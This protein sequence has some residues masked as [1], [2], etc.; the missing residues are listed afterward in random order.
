M[1]T[2]W[3]LRTLRRS[4]IFSSLGSML[5]VLVAASTTFLWIGA[6]QPSTSGAATEVWGAYSGGRWM[7]AD[8]NGGYWIAS[9][10]G[11]VTPYGGAPSLGSPS[12]FGIHLSQP[13]MGMAAT[14][15]GHGYWLVASDGGIFSFG[16]AAFHGSTGS[17]HLN[18]P[19]VGMAATPTGHGYWLV[20]SDGGIFSFGDAAFYGSTGSIHL[21][22]PIV[23][24]AATPTGHGYSLVASD[25]GIF[26]F[27]DATFHGSTGS[28]HLNQPIVGM[29]S[30]PDG[31]GYWLV[32]SDGGLFTFGDAA[33]HGSLGGSGRTVLGEVVTPSTSGYALIQ[34]NGTATSFNGPQSGSNP[35][36]STSQPVQIGGG[37]QGSDC[38]PTHQPT[39]RVAS[40]L[41]SV[42]A[43]ETGP[44][45]IGGD[46]TYSTQLPNGQESFV[47]SDTLIGTAQSSGQSSLTG[48]PRNSEL[49]GALPNL[50]VDAGGT[51]GSPSSLIPDP[52]GNDHW[53]TTS[54]YV[55]NGSQL[56]Y[57]N[58]FAPVPGSWDQFTGRS[59]IA[60]L[61][62]SGSGMPSFSSVMPLP[63]DPNTQWGLAVLQDTSYTYVYGLDSAVYAMKVARVPNG[64]SLQTSAWTYW[65]GSQWVTGEGNAVAINTGAELTG[66]TAQAG[67]VG[68]VGVAIPGGGYQGSA[69]T[70]SYA[71][72]PT[73]P[74]STPESVYSIPQVSEYPNEMA[75]MPTFHSE[76]TGQGGLVVSYNINSS[77]PA[78]VVQ[79]V[80]QYQP[81][82]L[83]LNN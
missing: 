66:V 65:N 43:N 75:Y 17:I 55:E 71:C 82:F 73:G 41:D 11:S 37:T 80:H 38:A 51:Y 6:A 16:D 58:E 23:G 7:A 83:L 57:V 10:A 4:R 40:G 69:V 26:S 61:S 49:V 39:A 32:A 45:W 63:T 9:M 35:A 36:V 81:H 54:T 33:F 5:A 21:N 28:I 74:W 34:T 3:R 53:W 8:P 70:L 22:Q 12:S 46:G 60:V 56:V 79:N 15:T 72:S 64:E 2:Y 29:A 1:R 52:G 18:K 44:G 68:Y 76:L 25:G 13:T 20:A 31:G 77:N 62:V 14:P 42:F 50:N 78:S 24:M 59:G 30:T 48:M 27:G 47:F 67:G 19:I